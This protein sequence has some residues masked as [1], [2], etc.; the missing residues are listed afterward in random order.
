MYPW[1]HLGVAYLLYSLYAHARFGRAPRPEP[2]LA[3]VAGSQLADVIDKPLAWWFGI[4]PTGRS[5]AHSLFFAAAL[6]V[7]VYAVGFALGRLETATAFVI[8]HL[9]HLAADIP[10]RA[11]LGYPHETEFLVWPLLDQPTFRFHDR[12][13][14][15]PAAVELVVGPFTNPLLFFLFEWVL[16]GLAMALWYVDGCPG[17]GYILPGSRS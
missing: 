14:E 7:V 12:L 16:L 17:L 11:L 9:S 8:A 1:G 6:V 3:V 13:F 4:L 10:P 2:A 15:P 5:L